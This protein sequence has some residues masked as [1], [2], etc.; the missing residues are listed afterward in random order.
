MAL[1][2]TGSMTIAP[3]YISLIS[4]TFLPEVNGV[5][6]T[7]GRLCDGLRA[8]GHRLQL[9]RPRQSCDNDRRSDDD[10]M[11][12]R[13]W[14][15]PGYPGLQWG[16]SCLHKLLRRWRQRKPDVL[17]IATEGPLGFSA[18]RAARRLGIPVVSGFHTNFQQYTGHYGA[19]L[20]TRLLTNYLRWFHN[21]TRLTLVPSVSQLQDLTRRG[22]E[23]LQLLSRGV[24]GQL[25]NPARRCPDLRAQW[26]LGE[27]DI[28]VIHVG[29]LAVEK[30]LGLL[31]ETF[32]RLQQ[33]YPQRRLKLVV[34]GDGP[35]RLPL[36]RALPDALFC[37][38]QRGEELARHYASGDLFLFPSLSETFGNVVLEA[39]AS[40]LAVV[41]FDQAA[42]AQHIRHGHN[43]ALALPDEP[44]SFIEAA[45]WLLEDPECLRRVRLNA[46]MHAG[47]QGWEA[48]VQQFE[49][50]LLHA[51]RPEV[52]APVGGSLPP[53]A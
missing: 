13:G 1:A 5:A 23:R 49:Q 47:R 36:Q 16:Q 42:A 15:L 33:R 4:E 3:L 41:A 14:P 30:N 31:G 34:V 17:Y 50:Y 37:G 44:N 52:Q 7:L 27:Q 10:L 48:I 51:R 39:L 45:T 11:L 43:G 38:V 26:G 2:D 28:A 18:L 21:A 22:F 46:R 40:G 6:N 12:I 8:A 19:G 53:H 20:L 25:F 32:Q 35:Q 9:V 24:D 29:R